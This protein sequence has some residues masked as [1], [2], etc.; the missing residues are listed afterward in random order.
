MHSTEPRATNTS[1]KRRFE[2][3]L[4]LQGWEVKSLR[5]GKANI[6]EAY[7]I[8]RDGEAYLFGSSFLPLQAASSHVVCDPTRTRKLL[9]SRRELDKLESLIA[10]QGYTI[11]PLALYWK[12]CWVKV[13]IGLVKGKK[14]HDKREDTKAREWDWEKA[15]IMKNKHRG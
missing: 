6:S 5:A 15:R 12:Q 4:S 10:R 11:V 9:L 2:A 13:E 7:V 1:S 3:G 14:E 8:F